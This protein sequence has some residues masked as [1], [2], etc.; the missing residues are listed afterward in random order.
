VCPAGFS[1]A[2][3]PCENVSFEFP[4]WS[5][6]CDRFAGRA[7]CSQVDPPR[8]RVHQRLDRSVLHDPQDDL[9]TEVQEA[10][11]QS[12]LAATKTSLGTDVIASYLTTQVLKEFQ[13]RFRGHAGGRHRR[14]P[15]GGPAGRAVLAD[16]SG[17]R[18]Q[19]IADQARLLAVEPQAHRG[20]VQLRQAST[21]E[22]LRDFYDKETRRRSP[23]GP[24]LHPP[25]RHQAGTGNAAPTEADYTR[26]RPRPPT[27]ANGSTPSPSMRSPACR[28]AQ[29]PGR[30]RR[31][32][33]HRRPARRRT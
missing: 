18:P 4:S 9:I 25:H 2:E 26:R 5:S 14:R 20:R 22:V 24:D 10:Q 7:G 28:G 13:E 6:C 32:L 27:S 8:C 3:P 21:A 1:Q 23:P 17:D 31:R 15:E 19:Q 29:R 16:G 12:S 33:R 30:R 11:S